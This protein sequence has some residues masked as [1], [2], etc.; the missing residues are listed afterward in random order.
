M[1]GPVGEFMGRRLAGFRAN[2]SAFAV[3]TVPAMIRPGANAVDRRRGMLKPRDYLASP[4]L[5]GRDPSSLI[6]P[7]GG[8]PYAAKVAWLQ[9]Q[10]L[11]QWRQNGCRPSG[12][13]IAA[14]VGCSP[15]TWSRT[16]IGERWIGDTI[17]TG[18]F[19]ALQETRRL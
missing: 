19:L 12:S 4:F 1:P 6:I 2:A 7:P 11:L 18:L 8:D 9:H 5:Y 14:S 3:G 17:L 15:S 10:L 13:A 16:A